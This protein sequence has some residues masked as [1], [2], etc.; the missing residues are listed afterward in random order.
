MT[1]TDFEFVEHVYSGGLASRAD[2]EGADELSSPERNV[3]LAWWAKGEIDNGGFA[4][5]YASQ[6]D[7]DEIIKAYLDI[8]LTEV[9]R[10]CE[11]SKRIFRTGFPPKDQEKRV[12]EV[13]QLTGLD[14]S[15][16]P[17]GEQNKVIWQMEAKFDSAVANYIRKNVGC[18]SAYTSM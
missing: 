16:D 4:L 18:F 15:I 5:L 12:A 8:G 10:A 3:L 2:R 1:L 14:G 13:D 17:W 6:V 11:E 7:I 9:A